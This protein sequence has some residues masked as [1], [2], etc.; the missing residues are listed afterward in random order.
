MNAYG[1]LIS[2]SIYA[3]MFSKAKEGIVLRGHKL[4]WLRRRNHWIRFART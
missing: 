4:S 3:T 1:I 2:G